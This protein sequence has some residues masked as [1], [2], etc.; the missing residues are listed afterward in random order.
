M[1][2]AVTPYDNEAGSKKQ[3][4]AEMFNN[5]SKTYDFLNFEFVFF[6]FVSSFG[7]L[8]FEFVFFEFV[9]NFVF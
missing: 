1:N 7:F 9:S 6:G 8:N 5:I 3:Q 2:K 4:V